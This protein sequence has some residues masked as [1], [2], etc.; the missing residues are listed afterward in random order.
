MW[1]WAGSSRKQLLKTSGVSAISLIFLGNGSYD[2]NEAL[3]EIV[4]HK[5]TQRF[6]RSDKSVYFPPEDPLICLQRDV[7]DFAL[8]AVKQGTGW[9]SEAEDLRRCHQKVESFSVIPADAG[10]QSLQSTKPGVSA[11]CI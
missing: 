1:P 6:L 10:I 7:Y 2:H 4:F 11:P 9:K 3:R 8:R 5:T